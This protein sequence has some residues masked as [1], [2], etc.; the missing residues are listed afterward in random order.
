MQN[1]VGL[2]R[3]QLGELPK[4]AAFL[5]SVARNSEETK[6]AYHTAVVDFQK[7]LNQKYPHQTPETIL[8]NLVSNKNNVYELLEGF[9]SFETKRKLSIRTIRQRLHAMKS[10]FGYHD[11]D[12][13]P[14]KFK[15]MVRT[16]KLHR[17]DEEAIDEKDIRKI[18]LA[19][20]N[21]RLRSYLLV[22]AS[23]GP[24]AKEALA[25]RLTDLD[26]SVKPTKLHIRKEYAKTRVARDVYISDEATQYLKSW[27]EWKYRDGGDKEKD[28]DD[29]VFAVWSQSESPG[30]LY[31]IVRREFAKL[32]ELVGF[33]GR[34][35]GM[36]R[37]KITL[38]SLRRFTKSV[39]ETQASESYS[40]WLLGHSDKSEYFT[41]KEPEKREIYATKCMKYLTFL[42]YT[43]L[44]ATSN[45]I[46]TKISEKEKEILLLRQRDSINTDAIA[47]LSDQVMKLMVEVQGLKKRSQ[48]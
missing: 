3:R 19:C 30:Q 26:F 43:T 22:L 31:P 45:N 7:F 46:E 16:P 29:L 42:D 36:K 9:V 33:G 28:R 41:K 4:V 25:I 24:R 2:T 15:R 34:K 14:Y 10:F 38:H 39:V 48:S 12:I 6:L 1:Q 23:G 17:E 13:I 8:R 11:I 44:E 47:N 5:E 37:R 20:N 21:R 18:L 35:E 40:E 32:L 27:I